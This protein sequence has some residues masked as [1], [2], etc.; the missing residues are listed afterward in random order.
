MART[1]YERFRLIVHG[2]VN[3][4]ADA[5]ED[6]EQSLNQLV[7]ELEEQ[8]E[9]AKRAAARAMAHE[10]ELTARL[11]H[12]REQVHTGD[13]DAERAI[14]R[15]RDDRAR[16]VLERVERD[17]QQIAHLEQERDAQREEVVEIRDSIAVMQRRVREARD[18]LE[19]LQAR[20]RQR[21]AR[22]AMGQVVRRVER[23][24]LMNEFDR[25]DR[26][27]TRESAE[28]RAYLRLDAE[29]SG[30][31]VRRACEDDRVADAVDDRLAEL[32]AR[33]DGATTG[34]A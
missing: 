6:P 14:E 25:L 2:S 21:D 30:D 8:L 34:G 12:L 33:R 17:R 15:G 19:V 23:T 28:S 10:D 5:V 1:L 16:A 4:F 24:G 18:R 3:R 27:V 22:E 20:M 29:L 31:D 9:E 26:R 11:A 32:R 13:A 7:I